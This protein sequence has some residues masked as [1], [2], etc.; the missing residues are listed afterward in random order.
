MH[1]K[2]GVSATFRSTRSSNVSAPRFGRPATWPIAAEREQSHD[3]GCP[4]R[5]SAVLDELSYVLN[6]DPIELRRRNEPQIDEGENRPFS[7]RSLMKCYDLGAERFGWSQRASRPRSMRDGRLLVGMGVA[8]ATYPAAQGA[9]SALVRLL[10]N[11]IAEVK[12]A[13]SDMGPGTYTSMTQVAADFLGLDV[14]QICFSLGR[15][16]FPLAPPHGGSQTMASVGSA[17]RAACI[18]VLERTVERAV[19]DQRSPTRLAYSCR[20]PPVGHHPMLNASL[21]C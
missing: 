7:S 14:E 8:S 5:R 12:V 13:A 17:V 1:I 21:S 4:Q 18:A 2:K 19:G 20:E 6:I 15:S 3:R 10:P 9:A 11:G 16:D